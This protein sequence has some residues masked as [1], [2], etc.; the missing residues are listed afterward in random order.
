LAITLK[1]CEVSAVAQKEIRGGIVGA[2]NKARWAKVLHVPAVNGLPGAR[3]AAVATRNEQS[4]REPA[5]TFGA[6]RWFS[7]ALAMIRD[8]RIDVVTIAVRVAA[9]RE[10]VQTAL[11]RSSTAGMRVGR[12]CQ[13]STVTTYPLP[14]RYFAFAGTGTP[15]VACLAEGM[16]CILIEREAEYIEDIRARLAHYEGESRHSLTAKARRGKPKE[17]LPLFDSEP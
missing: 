3:L 8:D 13:T 12:I 16:D 17:D 2:D 9:H 6:D 4:A 15:G 11:D 1:Y 14:C 7:D 10:T 5:K